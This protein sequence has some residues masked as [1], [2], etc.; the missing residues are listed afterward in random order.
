MNTPTGSG[1]YRK[2]GLNFS[3]FLKLCL[4]TY[5]PTIGSFIP[6]QTFIA[7]R[8]TE[9]TAAGNIAISVI[10]YVKNEPPISE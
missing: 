5:E 7:M 4:S 6:S 3:P 2:N 1:V 9:T 8:M 10:K